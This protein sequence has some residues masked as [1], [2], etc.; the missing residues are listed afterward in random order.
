LRSVLRIA[1]ALFSSQYALM[2]EYRAEIVLWALSGLLPLLMFSLWS[3]APAGAASGLSPQAFARDFLAAF[4]VRQFTI[5]WVVYAFE[6]DNLL[7]RLSPYLLQPLPL[8]WRYVAAHLAEQV[9]RLPFVVLIAAVFFL[10]QP[11]VLWI[12]SPGRI[13]ATVL[14]IWL[15]FTINFLLQSCIAILCFWSER[16][17][18][19]ERLLF[20]PY[21]FLSGLVAPLEVFPPALRAAA[22]WTPFPYMVAFPAQLLAGQ[23]VPIAASFAAMVG[24]ISLLLPIT[25][26]LWRAGV[27]R[28]SAMGA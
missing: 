21:L 24:W 6:E 26:L 2:L 20:I 18:A 10:L 17:S 14:A 15:A 4:V 11:A 28:Y 25:L 1:R 27:R 9:T 19:L 8:V 7:G 13:V 12:P 23:P 16:A 3:N 5:V 22:H